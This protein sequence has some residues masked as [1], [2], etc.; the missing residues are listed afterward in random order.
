MQKQ[1]ETIVPELSKQILLKISPELANTIDVAFSEH[2]KATG[3]ITITKAEYI[4][5]IL[6]KECQKKV[7]QRNNKKNSIG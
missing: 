5:R 1:K 3:D 7:K 6:Q 2:L 4:R